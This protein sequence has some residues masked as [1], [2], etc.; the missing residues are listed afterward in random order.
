MALLDARR[1][2]S[3]RRELL[4][5]HSFSDGHEALTVLLIEWERWA[6]TMLETHISHSILCYYRSQHDNQS[7]LSAL[8]SILDSCSLLITTVEGDNTGRRSLH[9]LSL[10]TCSSI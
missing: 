2:A 7:W 3:N 9:S 1:L 8:T 5:R 6:A 4:T 10:D